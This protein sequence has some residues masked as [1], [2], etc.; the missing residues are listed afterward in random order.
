MGD[1]FPQ[2]RG[3]SKRGPRGKLFMGI[4]SNLDF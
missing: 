4:N 2:E 1:E 3:V